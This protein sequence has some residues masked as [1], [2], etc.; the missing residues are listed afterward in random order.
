MLQFLYSI[1]YTCQEY[2][3]I[4][5][6]KMLMAAIEK[7]FTVQT[8]VNIVIFVMLKINE[9]WVYLSCEDCVLTNFLSF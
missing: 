4:Y 5:N 2:E 8:L 6:I 3:G 1:L 7:A 9:S